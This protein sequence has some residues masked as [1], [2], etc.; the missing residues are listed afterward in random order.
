MFGS[1]SKPA[2]GPVGRA[3]LQDILCEMGFPATQHNV[4]ALARLVGMMMIAH[5]C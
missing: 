4:D 2:K 3:F 5:A 1:K